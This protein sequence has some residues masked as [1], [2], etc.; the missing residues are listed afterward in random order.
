LNIAGASLRAV[1]SPEAP[2]ITK[3]VGGG[4]PNDCEMSC[5]IK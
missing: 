1:K 2:N 4:F 5:L 3:I